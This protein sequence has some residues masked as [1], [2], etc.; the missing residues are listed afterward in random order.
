MNLSDSSRLGSSYNAI[1]KMVENCS[2]LQCIFSEFLAAECYY[3]IVNIGI[4][5]LVQLGH[6]LTRFRMLCFEIATQDAMS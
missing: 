3:T 5:M 1:E 2:S 6:Q 4:E